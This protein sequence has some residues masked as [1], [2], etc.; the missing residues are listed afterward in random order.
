MRILHPVIAA[1]LSVCLLVVGFAAMHAE[2][3]NRTTRRLAEILIALTFLQPVLGVVD[4][5][6]MAPVWLQLL[7]LLGADLLVITFALLSAGVLLSGK[8]QLGRTRAGAV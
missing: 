7:H 2:R 4:F 6:L 3:S 1:A 5:V 8:R